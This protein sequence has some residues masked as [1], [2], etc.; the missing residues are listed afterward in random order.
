MRRPHDAQPVLRHDLFRRDEPAHAVNEDLRPAA[1][2]RGEP[3]I[4]QPPQGIL[5]RDA[6][7][8]GKV[9]YLRRRKGVNHNGGVSLA[10]GSQHVLVVR[11]R[12]V[13]VNAALYHDLRPACRR[14]LADLC[15]DLLHRQE[16]GVGRVLLRVERAEPALIHADVRIVDIAVDDERH[17]IAEPSPPLRIRLAPEGNGIAVRKEVC[18]LLLRKSHAPSPAAIG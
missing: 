11:E 2:E 15:E 18:R 6:L 14:C 5:D 9:Q 13:G 17:R 10:Y 7:L 16:I 3:R 1:G 4:L 8:L 12:Q